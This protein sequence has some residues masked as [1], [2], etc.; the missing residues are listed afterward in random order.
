MQT[1]KT[2]LK[3]QFLFFWPITALLELYPEVFIQIFTSDLAV[4]QE[5]T[6]MV[7]LYAAGFFVIPVQIVFQQIYLSTGQE[8]ACLLMVIIRKL[9]LHIPLLFILP[10][11]M[12]NKVLAVVLSAPLSD[13]ISVVV[14]L[15]FFVPS[16]YHSLPSDL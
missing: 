3:Y 8:R 15:L 1:A 5:A 2:L 6:W 4:I 9:I 12:K 16:F 14:T 7:R 10:M 11:V 13:V